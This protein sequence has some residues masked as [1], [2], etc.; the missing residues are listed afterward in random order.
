[1]NQIKSLGVLAGI[2]GI[3]FFNPAYPTDLIKQTPPNIVI[4]TCHDLGQHLGCYGIE[5]VNTPNL[6]KLASQGI[7]F[8]NFYSTSAVRSPGRGSLFTGRYPQS[9]GL[10]GL[11]HAPWWWKLNDDEQH[12]AQLLKSKDY[13]TTLIGFTHVGEPGRLGFEQH[14]ST[15]NNAKTTVSEAISFFNKSSNDDKPFFLKI[16]FTEVHDPYKQEADSSKGINIPSF[17][18]GTS[19]IRSE[20]AKFQGEIKFM[21]DCVG[22]IF[23]AI[24]ESE[25]TKNVIII[26]TSDHGIGFPGAKWTTRKAGTE[27]PFIIYQP[28]SI[29]SGGK[30]FNESMSNVDVLPTLFEYAGFS[31]PD[32]IEGVSFKKI[33]S[34][35]TNVPPRKSVFAQFTPDMKRDYQSRTVISGKYQLIRYFDAGRTVAYPLAIS[36]SRFSAHIERE[37]TTGARPFFELYDIENDPFELVNLGDKR[38]NVEIVTELSKELLQWMKAVNDPLLKG[39]IATPYYEKSMEDFLIQTR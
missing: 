23:D 32:N 25:V 15:K 4:I 38:E 6:D 13:N 24:A 36:P 11:T 18:A 37:K 39:P 14:L 10:M 31:I 33:F 26:F 21:D 35:E 27:V 30:V 5:T 22:K 1:M 8:R 2:T 19:E 9:N 3:S 34:G 7:M 16:G 12:I 29:F 20:L 17:L 28:N